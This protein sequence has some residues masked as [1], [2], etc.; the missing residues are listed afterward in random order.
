VTRAG[1]LALTAATFGVASTTWGQSVVTDATGRAVVVPAKIERVYAAGPPAATLLLAIAPQKLLGWTRVPRPDERAFLPDAVA[2]LPELGR[3]TGR[4]NSDNID[5]VLRAKP[6]VIVD[7]GSTSSRFVELAKRVQQQT[8][9]PYVLFDG[10]LART[11]QL[12]REIGRVVG[13]VENAE[14]LARDAEARLREVA[15]RLAR[16]PENERPR[17]YF[18]RGPG[19]LT[20]A[21]RGSFEAEPL[22]LAGG[23]NV[24]A[25]PPTFNGNQLG[26]SLDEVIAAQPDVIV[27]S[28]PTFASSVRTLP[29]WRDMPA[30]RNGR[31]YVAP[32]V[33]FGWLDA[34]PSLN[35]LLG[36]EWLARVLHPRSFREPL[37]PRIKAFYRLYYHREP[38]DDQLRALLATAGVP[39]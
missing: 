36:V 1:V 39:Q 14:A 31:V 12:L 34:P 10:T 4:D 8:G 15:D 11:P 9:I 23:A 3:I 24:I 28:D 25:A 6:D 2:A 16:I 35:R 7:V 37:G 30:I 33:P 32:A 13:M 18:A 17:V 27:T 38:T 22:A 20:T 5:V 26:I 29:G 19:G 21:P